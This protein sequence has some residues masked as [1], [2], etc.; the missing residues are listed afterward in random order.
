MLFFARPA[1]TF[2][3]SSAR[4][5][6]FFHHQ[7][8]S[9][10]SLMVRTDT[11]SIVHI[12]IQRA[13]Q[14]LSYINR[15]MYEFPRPICKD[16]PWK[17]TQPICDDF[18]QAQSNNSTEEMINTLY[19]RPHHVYTISICDFEWEELSSVHDAMNK[20]WLFW[21]TL[22]NERD[23]ALPELA[24]TSPVP[25]KQSLLNI[26]LISLLLFRKLQDDNVN[27]LL[28]KLFWVL[29]NSAPDL[30]NYREL[31]LLPQWAYDEPVVKALVDALNHEKS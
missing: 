15:I 14:P 26:C 1:A 29:A 2:F 9:F 23:T 30:D 27:S 31:K 25:E 24:D 3:L 19:F 5:Q 11:N 18:K 8:L 13:H 12:Q 21:R 16:A 4:S 7:K 20:H 10:R 28:E 6:A 17:V 22:H